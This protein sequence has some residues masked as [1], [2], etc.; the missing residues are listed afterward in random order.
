MKWVNVMDVFDLVILASMGVLVVFFASVAFVEWWAAR[1]AH[2][3]SGQRPDSHVIRHPQGD[4]RISA[5]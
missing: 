3:R 5:A 1:A 2:G 4:R